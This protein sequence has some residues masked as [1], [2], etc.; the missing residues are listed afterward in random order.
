MYNLI[1]DFV[2]EFPQEF[3]FI[4]PIAFILICLMV[5]Y[6]LFLFPFGDLK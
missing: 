4:F 5:I 1:S 2:G 3:Q 6:I